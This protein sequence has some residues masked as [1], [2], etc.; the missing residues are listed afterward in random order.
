MNH[1]ENSNDYLIETQPP[2]DQQYAVVEITTI[3]DI[4]TESKEGFFIEKFFQNFISHEVSQIEMIEQFHLKCAKKDNIYSNAEL[5][6]QDFIKH[7]KSMDFAMKYEQYVQENFPDLLQQYNKLTDNKSNVISFKIFRCYRTLE[8]CN[9]YIKNL[10]AEESYAKN[11][12]FVITPVGQYIPMDKRY[13]YFAKNQEEVMEGLNE[14]KKSQ[15][16]QD[17]WKSLEFNAR[18]KEKKKEMQELF[19]RI[20]NKNKEEREKIMET[21]DKISKDEE[22][23]KI[24]M[25]KKLAGFD[26][27]KDEKYHDTRKVSDQ[28]YWE[29]K[30]KERVNLSSYT[31]LLYQKYKET[32]KKEENKINV[33]VNGPK[34]M[35]ELLTNNEYDNVES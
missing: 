18:K 9:D 24:I 3:Q 11:V 22:E 7:L 19:N 12:K 29:E 17:I 5:F 13:D 26:T 25:L 16:R 21:N 8:E 4:V 15:K 14:L 34:L 10:R 30:E 35:D 32:L 2:I 33:N 20:N 28:M 23:D 6:I 27:D 31:E 1:I